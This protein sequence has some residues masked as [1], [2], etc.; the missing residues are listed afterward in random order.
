MTDET[1]VEQ[2]PYCFA[3]LRTA[4]P[5]M[6]EY[7]CGQKVSI[8]DTTIGRSKLCLKRENSLLKEINA[9]LKAEHNKL[10]KA[11]SDTV[12]ISRELAVKLVEVDGL[13]CRLC[14]GSWATGHKRDCPR[15]QL[16]QLL[17]TNQAAPE[18]A[19]VKK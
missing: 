9:A 10:R 13:V 12:T 19:E 4:W 16:Q 1:V 18:A 15:I 8:T 17:I 3:E 2:C 7:A 11:D 6:N 5:G 14:E